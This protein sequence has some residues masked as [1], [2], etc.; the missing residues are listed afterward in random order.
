[1]TSFIFT[2]NTREVERLAVTIGQLPNVVAGRVIVTALNS[3]V[4]RTYDLSRRRISAG[5]NL[6]DDYLRRR[7]VVEY[8]T[9]RKAEASIISPGG[10]GYQTQLSHYDATQEV[11]PVTWSNATIL[12]MGKK[13]GRWPGWTQRI[14]RPS[15]G[16]QPD[17][18]N[19]GRG[20][21]V[22][23]GSRKS[24]RSAF[25][26]PGRKDSEGNYLVFR[27][28]SN[29]KVN[30]LLGP[31]VYQLFRYQIPLIE[32]EVAA[33]L[34]QELLDNARIEIEKALNG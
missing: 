25:A 15:I 6:T 23:R 9:P 2:A 24:L 10:K 28:D 12:G 29:G 7:M 8:A 22:S 30:S 3:V 13:F 11:K 31:S 4:E 1:M 19:A 26:L 33:D 5:I 18:K 34:E 32:D 21:E 16:I 27:R 17:Q 14:G 20:A